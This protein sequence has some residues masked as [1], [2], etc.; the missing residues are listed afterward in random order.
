M[1]H[2][3]SFLQTLHHIKTN[4]NM[5]INVLFWWLNRVTLKDF[6]FF[7]ID[8]SIKATLTYASWKV[9]CTTKTQISPPLLSARL[10][11]APILRDTWTHFSE[12][13]VSTY[14]WCVAKPH[15][16]A[17][18]CTGDHRRSSV[19][20]RGFW[21]G[22]WDKA[23]REGSTHLGHRPRPQTLECDQPCKKQR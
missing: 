19:R 15:F 5:T 12:T 7:R 11:S 6:F 16:R 13:L 18:R 17:G 23:V 21:F 2:I 3:L 1:F 10:T 8:S 9:Y 4:V 22:T 20:H 14:G